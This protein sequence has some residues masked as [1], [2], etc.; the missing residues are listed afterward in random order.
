MRSLITD[1]NI[2]LWCGKLRGIGLLFLGFF[3]IEI[4]TQITWGMDTQRSQIHKENFIYS[5]Y[6]Q[7]CWWQK[8]ILKWA[9]QILAGIV[10]CILDIMSCICEWWQRS[11]CHG[12]VQQRDDQA[13]SKRAGSAMSCLSSA[14]SELLERVDGRV[15]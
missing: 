2:E 1:Q 13:K 14:I 11:L 4:D 12:V 3:K 7:L 5:S 9:P 6:L 10:V 15:A 8:K